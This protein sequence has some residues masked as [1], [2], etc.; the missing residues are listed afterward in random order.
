MTIDGV[1][2]KFL[3]AASMETLPIYPQSLSKC[4]ILCHCFEC[5][6]LSVVSLLC[7]SP[8]SQPCLAT[9]STFLKSVANFKI[10][11]DFPRNHKAN[12]LCYIVFRLKSID[13]G[14][15]S[16]HLFL[17]HIS[18]NVPTLL[19][20]SFIVFLHES[21]AGQK[22]SFENKHPRPV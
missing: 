15:K 3:T 7:I 14:C 10:C 2:S 13:R 9:V 12:C 16:L 4:G 8:L 22:C 21:S 11:A 6:S 1:N 19:A 5:L 17:S 18:H 20:C